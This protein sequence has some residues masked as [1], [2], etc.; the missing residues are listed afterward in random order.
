MGKPLML[1]AIVGLALVALAEYRKPTAAKTAGYRCKDG[2]CTPLYELCP[3]ARLAQLEARYT[4]ASSPV[5]DLPYELRQKNWSTAGGGSCVIASIITLLRWTG[6]PELMAMADHWREA[7]GGGQTSSSARRKLEESNLRYVMTCDGDVELLKWAVATRRGCAIAYAGHCTNIVG[8]E[9]GAW[10]R[11]D[12]N[13]TGE[14]QRLERLPSKFWAIA[15]VYDPP[16][17][18]PTY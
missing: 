7:Y 15:L 11:L 5:V 10:I 8:Y 17:P 4:A 18:L 2:V 3:P 9:D 1:I 6:D 14:Y 13:R 12:N 16:C